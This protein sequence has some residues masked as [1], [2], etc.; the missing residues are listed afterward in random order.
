MLAARPPILL[1]FTVN[2]GVQMVPR[3]GRTCNGIRPKPENRPA[4]L[5]A[6]E[7][8]RTS[9]EPP[10]GCRTSTLWRDPAGDSD[11]HGCRRAAA[12][13][14]F[15]TSAAVSGHQTDREPPTPRR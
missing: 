10:N 15:V 7:P 1:G 8:G 11:S 3:I 12:A 4:N 2:P 5:R 14:I 6:L 9:T 13:S